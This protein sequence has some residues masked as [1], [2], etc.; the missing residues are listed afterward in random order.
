MFRRHSELPVAARSSCSSALRRTRHDGC[1]TEDQQEHRHDGDDAGNEI[2]MK[3]RCL[4]PFELQYNQLS[5]T[6]DGSRI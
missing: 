6:Q 3:V 5:W 2:G 4:A 1:V